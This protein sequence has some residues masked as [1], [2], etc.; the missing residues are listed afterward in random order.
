MTYSPFVFS[1]SKRHFSEIFLLKMSKVN[2]TEEDQVENLYLQGTGGEMQ[3]ST[4]R[5]FPPLSQ[6]LKIYIYFEVT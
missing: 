6:N 4:K 2:V 5:V 1:F 3:V